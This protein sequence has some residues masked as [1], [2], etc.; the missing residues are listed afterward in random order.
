MAEVTA[1]PPNN[2]PVPAEQAEAEESGLGALLKECEWWQIVGFAI[3]AAFGAY[4][5]ITLVP[6][7]AGVLGAGLI[8]LMLTIAVIDGRTYIIPNWLNACGFALAMLHAAVN[9]PDDRL[10]SMGIAALRGGVLLLVFLV[11]RIGYSA[12][13]GRQG[14]GFGDVK[15]AGVAGAWLEWFMLPIVVEIAAVAALATYVL[16][17]MLLRRSMSRADRLPFGL[18]LAPAIWLSWLVQSSLLAIF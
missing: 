4:L 7:I 2:R 3:A 9:E 15:L 11:V 10:M 8:L 18:Y 12:I 1:S 14:L 6:N 13:R 17:H 16:R 5:S